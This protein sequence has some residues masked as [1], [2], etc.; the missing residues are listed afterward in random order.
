MSQRS[1]IAAFLI[2]LPALFVVSPLYS[3]IIEIREDNGKMIAC[4]QSGLHGFSRSCGA[5]AGDKYVF[6]GSV[7]SVSDAPENEQRVLLAPEEVFFGDPGKEIV[8]TTN[9]RRCLPE[10]HSGDRWLFYLY[11]EHEKK[12]LLLAYAS[13]SAPVADAE[14]SIARLRR[15][16]GMAG[17]G[18]IQGDV[19]REIPGPDDNKLNYESVPRHRVIATQKDTGAQYIA[20]TNDE[21]NYEFEPLPSGS[22]ELTANTAEGWW[23]EEGRVDVHQSGCKY[24]GFELVPDS[25]ISGRVRLLGTDSEQAIWV[26]AIAAAGDESHST[27]ADKE[28]H[29]QFRGLRPGRYL[30][31]ADI[32]GLDSKRRVYYP[33]VRR[34]ELAIVI[35][36]ARGEQRSN[37]D[38]AIPAR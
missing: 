30:I 27:F 12:N 15:L 28:G 7:I 14:K 10:L 11:E 17:A 19:Q 8:A 22:Y 3:Q 37:V 36:I 26:E 5:D 29:F 25:L 9:Q 24:V 16:S 2:M 4:T 38:I 1:T 23:A 32:G 33:G 21:G 18:L 6:I 34:K 13:G 31:V 20:I 35:E